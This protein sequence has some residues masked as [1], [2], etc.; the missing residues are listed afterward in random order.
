MWL[1]YFLPIDQVPP[2]DEGFA[3]KRE[4]YNRDDV[5]N[6]NSLSNAKV[7]DI[8]RGNLTITV[9]K[10]S[11]FVAVED[12]I[13]AGM[14][15]VNLR[16]ATE[17]QSLKK[18]EPSYYDYGPYGASQKSRGIFSSF[19]ENLLR[20]FTNSF[21][22]I[23]VEEYAELDYDD[24]VNT[25]R[26]ALLRPDAEESH[27][28]RLFL[29]QEQVQPGVYE[30]EYFVRALIPGTYHHLPAVVSE[31]YFPENFGRTDGRYFTITR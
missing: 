21:A 26:H 4:F 3:I 28:D 11:N 23:G 14:E 20:A 12:F 9:P 18:E 1:K 24:Y 8:L 29:F 22:G 16:L 15:I 19:T 25:P 31:M 5:N 13:P 6:E 30:F 10:S 27:D 2:R 7:G 17:D